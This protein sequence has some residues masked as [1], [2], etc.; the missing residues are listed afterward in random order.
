MPAGRVLPPGVSDGEL[1]PSR[2]VLVERDCDRV[3]AVERLSGLVDLQHG[4]PDALRAEVQADREREEPL[5]D[6]DLALLAEGPVE[7]SA[8]RPC[9]DAE[10][11]FGTGVASGDGEPR[12]TERRRLRR[13]RNIGM[14]AELPE[15]TIDSSSSS[16]HWTSTRLTSVPMNADHLV[17]LAT[18]HTASSPVATVLSKRARSYISN[19][20]PQ[21]NPTTLPS[22]N[23]RSRP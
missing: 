4:D 6:L 3:G 15:M 17:R 16:T 1:E 8:S 12:F 10:C 21:V 11:P 18:S 5:P 9:A 19:F 14:R 7:P 13:I 22:A 23:T 2:D 20:W